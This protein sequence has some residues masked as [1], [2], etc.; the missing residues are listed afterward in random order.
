VSERQKLVDLVV[1]HEGVRLTLYLDSLGVPTIGIGRNLKDKGI[2]SAE[3]FALLD[4][5]LDECIT[6]LSGSFVWFLDL[7][8]VRQR[9]LVDLRFQLGAAGI[10]G[11]RK[12]LAACGRGDF[13]MASNELLASH[14]A[15]QTPNRAIELAGMLHT[16]KDT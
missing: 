6:D 12:M 14:L 3:A 1:K 9:V 10:R 11:F 2:S 13:T 16:G 4:H 7:D 15:E 5:D 8:A